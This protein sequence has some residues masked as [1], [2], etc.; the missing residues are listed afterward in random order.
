MV[1]ASRTY[2]VNIESRSIRRDEGK[3][4]HDDGESYAIG[5]AMPAARRCLDVLISE[6]VAGSQ[7]QTDLFSPHRSLKGPHVP[8]KACDLYW[9]WMSGVEVCGTASR[10]S[11]NAQYLTCYPWHLQV[12][13]SYG[14]TR[15]RSVWTMW[16]R[17]CAPFAPLTASSVPLQETMSFLAVFVSFGSRAFRVDEL[18]M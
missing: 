15:K 10:P 3:G 2:R 4:R 11:M 9:T 1:L 12:A 7:W 18:G 13:R 16:C 8:Q 5:D 14:M 17:R 6:F